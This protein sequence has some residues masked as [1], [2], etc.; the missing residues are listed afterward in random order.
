MTVEKLDKRFGVIAIEK[1]FITPEQLFEALKIQ[2]IEEI[3]NSKH[4]LIGEILR[5]KGYLTKSQ[6]NEV[7]E[8]MG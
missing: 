3:E 6:V 2:I 5:D 4:Q 8:S 7:L 1:E